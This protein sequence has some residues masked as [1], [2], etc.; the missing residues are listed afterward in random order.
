MTEKKQ[1]L[2]VIAKPSLLK[3]SGAKRKLLDKIIL[4]GNTSLLALRQKSLEEPNGVF[5]AITSLS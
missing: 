1:T 2:L 4:E 5:D 3:A